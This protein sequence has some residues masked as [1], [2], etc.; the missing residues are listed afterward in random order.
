MPHLIALPG[1]LLDGESLTDALSSATA[2]LAQRGIVLTTQIEVL[3]LA[4]SLPLECDRLSALVGSREPVWWLGHSLGAIVAL[5]IARRTPT[6]VQ[7]LIC[8]ASTARA[9]APGN[10]SIRQTQLRRA[11]V[12]GHPKSVSLE[13]KNVFG[14]DEGSALGRQL[15]AQAERVGLE[16]YRLQTLYAISREDQREKGRLNCPILA[17]SGSHDALCPPDR[18]VEI[19]ALSSRSRVIE[20]TGAGHLLAST[21][22]DAIGHQVAEFIA[23]ID[24]TTATSTGKSSVALIYAGS[25]HA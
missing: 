17:I 12:D 9:D 22:A 1:T 8:L 25:R 3:G 19:A 23:M 14:V 2:V 16:R 13:L 10:L 18:S 24:A 5:A 11:E 6:A 7:G 4:P 21:H 15:M 20:L